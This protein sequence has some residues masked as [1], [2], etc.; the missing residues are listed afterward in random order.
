MFSQNDITTFILVDL[1]STVRHWSMWWRHRSTLTLIGQS[2]CG[3]HSC[4]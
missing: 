3:R 4:R 1:A 2:S